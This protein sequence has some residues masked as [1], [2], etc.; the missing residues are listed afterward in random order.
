MIQQI[1]KLNSIELSLEEA[2]FYGFFLLLS[3]T[4]GLGFYE[5]QKQFLLLVVPAL[6]LG[7][8]KILITSYTRWQLVLQ[9]VFLIMTA[10]VYYN[11]RHLGIVFL[12]FTVLGM[13]NISVKKVFHLGLW[14][15]SVCAVL[16]SI[17]SFFRLEHTIYRVHAK[18]GL[19]HIFRW[20]LGFTHPNILHITYL[21]LCAFILYEMGERYSLKHFIYLMA[22]NL[23]VF[24]YS[25]SYTG[26]GIVAVLLIGCLYVRLRPRFSILEKML[27]NLVLPVCLILSFVLPFYINDH[28][29]SAYVQKLNFMLNTRIWLAEQFLKSEYRSLLGADISQIVSSSMTLDNSY[30]WGYINYGLIPFVSI[31]IGYFALL[32]YD[33]HK[34]R[35]RELVILVCFLAAGWTE[36]LLFNT[37][38]KNITLIFLG[39][40][41]F[42]QKEDNAET[43][44]ADVAAG[45]PEYRLLPG[46]NRRIKIPF[47]AMPDRL[48]HGAAAVWKTHKRKLLLA[49]A[50]GAVLGMLLCAVLYD[51][52]KGYV[53]QRFYTDGLE[54]TSVYLESEDDPAYE[55]YTVM[56][57]KDAETP[58]QI[59]SGKAV[60]LET[61]RYYVGSLLIGALTGAAF[62]ICLAA[63][64]EEDKSSLSDISHEEHNH[65][66]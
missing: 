46:G 51:E 66:Q 42:M 37:S 18:L 32:F 29:I 41:L 33:T 8:A 1:G 4:K 38:F 12:A 27:V 23:L 2:C 40:L 11:S 9:A 34:Q 47:A 5:G 24:L 64:R 16:L 10:V 13:K 52:P 57:Y 14:V 26:F 30:V 3:I 65:E 28:R 59:I 17:F 62:G 60:K 44:V 36:P 48:A 39:G 25:V 35:T 50:G 21:A 55:G 45:K 6:L 15:W 43:V 20:S 22:G 53:V 49:V 63:W 31:M 7:F 61:V 58:M 19:G 56:N 54:E